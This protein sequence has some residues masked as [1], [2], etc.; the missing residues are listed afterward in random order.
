MIVAPGVS[1]SRRTNL[2]AN[3]RLIYSRPMTL[4][5]WP[6]KFPALKC[7]GLALLALGMSAC[8]AYQ[9]LTDG[10]RD[11]I[12]MKCPDYRVIADAANLVKFKDGPGRDLV[13]V[14]FEGEILG[15]DLECESDIDRPTRTGTLEVAVKITI[16]A[17][18][19]PANR[20]RKA[21]FD[22]FIRVVDQNR[23][24]LKFLDDD[25]NPVKKDLGVVTSFPGNKTRVQFRTPP[26][27]LKLPISRKWSSSYYKIFVGFKPTR[28]ELQ[29]NRDKIQNTK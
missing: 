29:F 2:A 13:D 19:G 25:G 23:K 9:N 1:L 20:D 26:F 10:Y 8:T 4:R 18:R 22:Y 5:L 7:L 11:P 27:T 24:I 16:G 15:V 14:N 17:S 3:R 12:V 21:R 28:A 6:Q